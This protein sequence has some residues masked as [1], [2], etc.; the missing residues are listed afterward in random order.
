[1]PWSIFPFIPSFILTI[2][3]IL[4]MDLAV[5]LLVSL[6][7]ICAFLVALFSIYYVFVEKDSKRFYYKIAFPSLLSVII[8]MTVRRLIFEIQGGTMDNFHAYLLVYIDHL[9]GCIATNLIALSAVALGLPIWISLMKMFLLNGSNGAGLLTH[10][11]RFAENKGQ[12][13]IYIL[14]SLATVI[15]LSSTAL[16]PRIVLADIL[17]MYIYMAI[18]PFVTIPLLPTIYY[19]LLLLIKSQKESKI[20]KSEIPQARKEAV[21]L[22]V[23]FVAIVAVTVLWIPMDG[24]VYLR[25]PFKDKSDIWY[26]ESCSNSGDLFSFAFDLIV[27]ASGFLACFNFRDSPLNWLG[28]RRTMSNTSGMGSRTKNFLSI[29]TKGKNITLSSEVLKA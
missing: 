21:K 27:T 24:I 14:M 9:L 16:L 23:I 2:F 7:S 25:I 15:F 12:K 28:Q 6:S 10:M 8:M 26:S 29:S 3:E 18:A 11:V 5:I 20:S 4:S 17:L 1:M 22:V 19:L 13:A